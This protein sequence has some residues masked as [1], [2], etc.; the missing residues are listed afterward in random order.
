M[1]VI[2]VLLVLYLWE[3]YKK[4]KFKKISQKIYAGFVFFVWLIFVPNAAYIITDIRH[5][6]GYCPIDSYLKVCPQNA[7][8][9][10]FFYFYSLVGW[11]INVY[12]LLK[13]ELLIAK[14]YNKKTAR[15]FAYLLIPLVSLGVMLGLVDRWNSW[16]I[17]VYPVAILKS[18]WRYFTSWIYFRNWLVFSLGLYASYFIAKKFIKKI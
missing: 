3:L 1:A 2:P 13:M 18:I 16:E 17:F 5:I 4:N 11:L 14:I 9:I 8:M 15:M 6:S 10:M 12:L 7:W